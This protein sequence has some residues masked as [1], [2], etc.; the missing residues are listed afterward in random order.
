LFGTGKT[1]IEFR[2]TGVTVT[3]WCV[4]TPLKVIPHRTAAAKETEPVQVREEITRYL[5]Q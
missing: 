3:K 2:N 4:R 5:N 1:P